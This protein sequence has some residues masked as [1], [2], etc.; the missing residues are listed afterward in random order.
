VNEER[1]AYLSAI[2]RTFVTL[3]GRGFMLSPKEVALVDQ[4]FQA[5]VPARIVIRTLQEGFARRTQRR[6]AP[7]S[8]LTYFE[9]QIDAAIGDWSRK[10]TS[11]P[12]QEMLEEGSPASQVESG[13]SVLI[14]AASSPEVVALL[15]GLRVE[16]SSTA[17][18]QDV[19]SL[20]M[21]LDERIVAGLSEMLGE[22]ERSKM[23]QTA[24]QVAMS[25]GNMSARARA[26]LEQA[27][28][29]RSIRAHF[30]LP[31]LSESLS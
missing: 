15:D 1:R 27:E 31:R 24:H 11:A 29:A 12:V 14:E 30:Q 26:G 23:T 22:E 6:Q 8:T 4:W 13:L 20:T 21:A 3:R 9:S 18:E 19:Y 7:P 17:Q 28:L 10:L 2:E 16:L 5:G 25:A